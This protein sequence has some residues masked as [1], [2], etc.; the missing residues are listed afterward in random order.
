MGLVLLLA[1]SASARMQLLRRYIFFSHGSMK[2]YYGAFA[3]EARSALLVFFWQ[4]SRI[5]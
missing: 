3:P 2:Q 1:K 4:Q 5:D